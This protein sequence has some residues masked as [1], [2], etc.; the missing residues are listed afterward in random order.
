MPT[1]F[2]LIG[3]KGSPSKSEGRRKPN[4]AALSRAL[5]AGL[6]NAG[7]LRLED[8]NEDRFC[9]TLT[10]A[11]GTYLIFPA[12]GKALDHIPRRYSRIP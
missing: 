3:C 5:N 2:G 8:P 12:S 4:S 10:T 11:E 9:E 1:A 7:V 6:E